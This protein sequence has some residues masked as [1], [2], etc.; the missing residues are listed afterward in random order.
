MTNI[1]AV[2][3]AHADPTQFRRLVAAL[4]DV[5][6]FLHCDA[7]APPE[8]YHQMVQG[9]PPRVVL[10]DRHRTSVAS[11]SLVDAELG[12][13]REAMRRTSAEHIMVLSGADYPLVS[14]QELA[15][16]LSLWD[17]ATYLWNVPLPFSPWDTPQH[18]DGGLWRTRSRFIVI[19]RQVA[20]V[21]GVPLRWPIKRDVSPELELRAASQW[22]IYARRHVEILLEVVEKRPDLIRFWRGTLVPDE[23]FVASML[24]SPKLVGSEALPI[25]YDDAWYLDWSVSDG[26]PKVLDSSDFDKLAEAR[27][28]IPSTPAT[29]SVLDGQ[30]RPLER[31]LFARKFTT[32][33]SEAV[34]N[35]VDHELRT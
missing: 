10:C 22:K 8:I 16:S 35:R 12:A 25:C 30:P 19:R 9:L 4:N 17:G 11:W 5:P 3:L 21:R 32:A 20:F 13:L 2:V 34:L 6:I 31:K 7:K 23:S 14:M 1:A 26:H 24:A 15:D 18:P 27:W 28:A 29:A 33:G